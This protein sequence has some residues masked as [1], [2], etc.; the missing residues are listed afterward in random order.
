MDLVLKEKLD[1]VHLQKEEG[2]RWA[3][4]RGRGWGEEGVGKGVGRGR[5]WGGGGEGV[6]GEVNCAAAT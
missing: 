3:Q 6:G 1:N 2:R 4:Q 5:G